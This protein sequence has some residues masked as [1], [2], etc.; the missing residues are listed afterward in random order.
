MNRVFK[1]VVIAFLLMNILSLTGVLFNSFDDVQF[2]LVG[3]A[4]SEVINGFDGFAEIFV[5]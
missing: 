5:E 1:G 4:I 2:M 3:D